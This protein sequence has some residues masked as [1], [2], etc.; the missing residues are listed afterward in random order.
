MRELY[1]KEALLYIP[2]LLQLID[3]NLIEISIAPLMDVLIA[4]FDTIALWI[5]PVECIRNVSFPS[6]C[7]FSIDILETGSIRKSFSGN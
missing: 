6:R 4:L 7:A 5:F 1:V 2:R 3:R